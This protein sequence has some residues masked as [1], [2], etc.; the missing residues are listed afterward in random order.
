MPPKHVHWADEE[1]EGA[2]IF[3]P[4]SP[5]YGSIPSLTTSDD[6]FADSSVLST[7]IIPDPQEI[8]DAIGQNTDLPANPVWSQ[9]TPHQSAV[10]LALDPSSGTDT[11]SPPRMNINNQENA[12]G[13]NINFTP[14][15]P[16]PVESAQPAAA[17][18][19]PT[20]H[21]FLAY[22]L[23]TPMLIWDMCEAP[24][25]ASLRVV[26][27]SPI[28]ESILYSIATNPTLQEMKIACF[29][30][31]SWTPLTLKAEVG[32]QSMSSTSGVTLL[33][34]TES[35]ITVLS[36]LRGIYY[37]L[38]KRVSAT[39]Y[40]EFSAVPGL[41]DAVSRSF[42]SRCERHGRIHAT[43]TDDPASV[44]ARE[45]MNG[46]KRLD[47]LLGQTQ[48]LGLVNVQRD[49]SF[50]RLMTGPVGTDS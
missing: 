32:R 13:S 6:S 45:K 33:F 23:R 25:L 37:Y 31:P 10:N 39:E 48:F 19:L 38:Q 9:Q 17:P 30:H 28:S 3:F 14:P 15:C 16:P 5:T 43:T 40:A 41:Q 29:M 20:L 47:C 18:R 44:T 42:Y 4:P 27:G 11:Y 21:K 8:L 50:W 12:S 46:L 35:P 2:S 7:P 34:E 26:A 49:P 24:S 22:P 36:V 1:D